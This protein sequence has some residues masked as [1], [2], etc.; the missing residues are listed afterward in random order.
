M[1]PEAKFFPTDMYLPLR[2]SAISTSANPVTYVKVNSWLGAD[3]YGGLITAPATDTP[4]T[5][6]P[7]LAPFIPIA[8]QHRYAMVWLDTFTE[9]YQITA[10]VSQSM[11][12]PL[13]LTDIAELFVD[14]PADGVP[15]KAYYLKDNQGAVLQSAKEV[16]MRQLINVPDAVGYANPVTRHTRIRDNRE[17]ATRGVITVTSATLTVY[18]TIWN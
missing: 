4:P 15:I 11:F 10:S 3:E 2:S 6:N 12:T 13:D 18:G 5:G 8:Q 9:Q 17:L 14:R 1:L 16:D 7:D